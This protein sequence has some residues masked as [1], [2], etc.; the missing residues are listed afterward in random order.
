MKQVYFLC[1]FEIDLIRCSVCGNSRSFLRSYRRSSWHSVG[2]LP[3]LVL[4]F[5]GLLESGVMSTRHKVVGVHLTTWLPS[6]HISIIQ[7]F[8]L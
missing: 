7:G 3:V 4:F 2:F 6:T 5:A 8:E 1:V